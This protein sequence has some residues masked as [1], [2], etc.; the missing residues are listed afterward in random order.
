MPGSLLESLH[1]NPAY[2]RLLESHIH[3]DPHV[4]WSP[5]SN[6]QLSLPAFGHPNHG[7]VGTID[8]KTPLLSSGLTRSHPTKLLGPP[9][10]LD[11]PGAEFRGGVCCHPSL[12][13]SCLFLFC[14]GRMFINGDLGLIIG[15]TC[16]GS[17]GCMSLVLAG[18]A[19]FRNVRWVPCKVGFPA[20]ISGFRPFQA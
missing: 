10:S 12:G 7:P 19:G 17:S 3:S 6:G 14:V 11:F 2:Q 5:G 20:V 13:S 1:F 18:I 9:T 15:D 4:S 16:V 8:R